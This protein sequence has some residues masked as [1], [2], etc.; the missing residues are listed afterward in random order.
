MRYEV[1]SF[2][3]LHICTSKFN[4]LTFIRKNTTYNAKLT[5]ALQNGIKYI[6]LTI[7]MCSLLYCYQNRLN[8]SRITYM[9]YII[10]ET[11]K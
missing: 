2:D 10:I 8:L 11:I 4:H 1:I 6:T 7:Y 9:V 5:N 3:F